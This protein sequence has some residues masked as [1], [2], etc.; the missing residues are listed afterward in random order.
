VLETFVGDP[1][2]TLIVAGDEQDFWYN[3]DLDQFE[4]PGKIDATAQTHPTIFARLKQF[5]Q[6][7]RLVKMRGNHDSLYREAAALSR[8][9]SLGFTG[10]QVYDYALIKFQQ[11]D[12]LV[13]HGQQ[14]DPFNCDANEAF[15]KFVCNFISEPIDALDAVVKRRFGKR[16]PDATLE[17]AFISPYYTPQQ[18]P[19]QLKSPN[20]D[21]PAI[22]DGA[23]FKET[24]V[25][26]QIRKF[27][28]SIVCGHTHGPKILKVRSSSG[29]ADRFYANIGTC[30]WWEGA[31]W[32]LQ[33]EPDDLV[34]S[35]W[36]P[37]ASGA[38]NLQK[39]YRLSQATVTV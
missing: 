36:T 11:R 23:T 22:A 8:Y 32:T 2:Y 5:H 35:L 13:M 33:I 19:K 20:A 16:F 1:T 21:A 6:A 7:D 25:I 31:V 17:G 27:G 15:G 18:W 14:F 4:S 38:A 12:L 28:T 3:A 26:E 37:G 29:S 39:N 30:G 9:R 24:P 10:L 34:L